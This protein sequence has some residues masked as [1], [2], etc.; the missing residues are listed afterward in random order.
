MLVI[1]R[2]VIRSL[3]IG[4]LVMIGLSAPWS[5]LVVLNLR[6]TPNLPWSIPLAVAY[7]VFAIPY[8]NGCGWPASTSE[9]RHRSFRIRWLPPEEWAWALLAGLF[10]VG[11]L[12][13]AFAALGY[14]G[15]QSPPGQEAALSP[16]LL[17][18]LVVIS[19][20]VTAL[21]EEAACRGYMQV[22]LEQSL[23]PVAA[24][25]I[26]SITFVLLHLSHGLSAL[27]RYGEFYFA[28][29]C[30]YGTLAYLTQSILPSLVLHFVG[31]IPIFATRSSVLHFSGPTTSFGRWSC[32]CGGLVMA[33]LG[34]PAFMR[35]AR[36]TTLVREEA[37]QLSRP[38]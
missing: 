22:P 17:C 8:L 11:S 33:L 4:F 38:L 28:V 6:F 26:T 2:S 24:I 19:A 1:L 31:D 10:T 27:L 9:L 12:W 20:A 15:S 30:I 35:L 5:F 29:G 16:V 3:L 13:L 37:S 18:A 21:S 34:I 23:G 14:L 25:A 36:I 7:F 32:I